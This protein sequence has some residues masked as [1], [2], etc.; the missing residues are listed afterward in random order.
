[1]VVFLFY[2]KMVSVSNI[3]RERQSDQR[4]SVNKARGAALARASFTFLRL[5][6]HRARSRMLAVDLWRVR[7]GRLNAETL[8]LKD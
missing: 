8:G 1:L 3:Y 7:T 6:P 4:P 2:Q 5:D